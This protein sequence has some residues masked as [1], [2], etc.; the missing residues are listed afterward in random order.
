MIGINGLNTEGKLLN[1]WDQILSDIN[2]IG[3]IPFQK[4]M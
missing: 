1:E 4:Q 2:L 3:N